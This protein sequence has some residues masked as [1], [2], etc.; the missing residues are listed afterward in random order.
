VTTGVRAP[1]SRI[2][3]RPDERSGGRGQASPGR[4]AGLTAALAFALLLLAAGVVVAPPTGARPYAPAF[5]G[6]QDGPAAMMNRHDGQAFGSLA[7]DPLLAHPER[8]TEGAPALAYRASRPLLGW[9]VGL[10]SLGSSERAAWS[11]LVWTAVGI[12][13]VAAAAAALSRRWS[14][15]PNWVPLLLVVPGIAGQLLFPGLS[16]GVATGLVLVGLAWWIDGRD[17]G[18]VALFCLAVLCRETTLLVPLAL[19]L[20]AGWRRGRILLVPAGAYAAWVGIVWLRLHALPSDASQG[21]IGI[22][23]R[24]CCRPCP[25][26]PGWPG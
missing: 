18:A 2:P 9:L 24:A 21:R 17:R 13:M 10:T 1:R 19:L 7:L 22:P 4:T 25:V 16:D 26:G 8:W 6:A 12:G 14:R 15:S 23:L 5:R 20:T 3:G 11:L